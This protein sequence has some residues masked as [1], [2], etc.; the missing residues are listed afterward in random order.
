MALTEQPAFFIGIKED[1]LIE[2]RKT[3]RIF[4]D[5]VFL[6]EKHHREVLEPGQDVTSYPNKLRQIAA[7]VWTPAVIAAYLA[8]KAAQQLPT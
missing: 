8:A 1:G 2:Y 5:G 7:V 3:R 4:E 6:T